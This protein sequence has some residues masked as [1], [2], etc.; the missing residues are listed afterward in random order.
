MVRP[1]LTRHDF[2]NIFQMEHFSA[3]K[4]AMGY[5]KNISYLVTPKSP[6]VGQKLN[7]SDWAPLNKKH[8]FRPTNPN[9]Q[10]FHFRA[11]QQFSFLGLMCIGTAP[12]SIDYCVG[13][14]II[15]GTNHDFLLVRKTHKSFLEARKYYFKTNNK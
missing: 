7:K 15:K 1:T 14:Y 6:K 4:F 10:K 8:Y 2:V 12:Y 5:E 9:I 11:R 3:V 13:V